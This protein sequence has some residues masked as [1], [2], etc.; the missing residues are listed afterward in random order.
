MHKRTRLVKRVV[1]APGDYRI[2]ELVFGCDFIVVEKGQ[3]TG[4]TFPIWDTWDNTIDS[5]EQVPLTLTYTKSKSWRSL[6]L[7]WRLSIVVSDGKNTVDVTERTPSEVPITISV[8]RR[9]L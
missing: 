5:S 7:R 1:L 4:K 2:S 3:L 8:H 9:M 6:W